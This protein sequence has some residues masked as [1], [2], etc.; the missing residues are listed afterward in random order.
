MAAAL[1][2]AVGVPYLLPYM[3]ERYFFLADVIAAAWAC[4]Q[5]KR[6]PLAVCVEGGSLASYV[7]YLR[8]KYNWILYAFGTYWVMAGESLLMLAALVLA[9]GTFFRALSKKR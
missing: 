3:H 6:L 4:A 9:A 8:L 1:V 2:L 7:V 5:W